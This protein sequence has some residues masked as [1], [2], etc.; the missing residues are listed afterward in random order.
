MLQS[1]DSA[2]MPCKSKYQIRVVNYERLSSCATA[3]GARFQI[4]ILLIIAGSWLSTSGIAT[5]TAGIVLNN[6]NS[7]WKCINS[8]SIQI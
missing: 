2:Q 8:N 6:S 3:E 4:N 1:V 5:A 7:E